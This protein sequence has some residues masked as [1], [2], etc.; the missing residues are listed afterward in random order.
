MFQSGK[1][2]IDLKPTTLHWRPLSTPT[3]KQC[4]IILKTQTSLHW[5]PK[6]VHYLQRKKISIIILKT[7]ISAF[8]VWFTLT[9]KNSTLS[10][11]KKSDIIILKTVSTALTTTTVHY[12]SSIF[13]TKYLYYL[14]TQSIEFSVWFTLTTIVNQKQYI[15]YRRKK[16]LEL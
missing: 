1:L 4:D 12:L 11:D 7:I 5:Q 3:Q 10:S 16:I 14:Q 15:I 9:T 2:F 13:K 8:S 6:T